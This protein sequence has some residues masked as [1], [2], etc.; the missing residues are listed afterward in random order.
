[1]TEVNAAADA[2][3]RQVVTSEQ[4]ADLAD[5]GNSRAV[6]AAAGQGCMCRKQRAP[7][8]ARHSVIADR[9]FRPDSQCAGASG[10]PSSNRI[11]RVPPGRGCHDAIVDPHTKATAR[12][13]W[14]CSTPISRAFADRHDP[15]TSH[16][17]R[18][19]RELV[20]QCSKRV[21]SRTVHPNRGARWVISPLLPTLLCT[22]WR[23][24]PESLPPPALVP[25]RR[26]RTAVIVTPMIF[27]PYAIRATGREQVR[28]GG[29][30]SPGVWSST[31]TR[32]NPHLRRILG[33]SIRRASD[34]KLR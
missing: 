6:V 15:S 18:S 16:W 28:R 17:G 19:R 4:K 5:W 7:P 27:W 24:P 8:P 20:R 13:V 11:L 14:G 25:G 3:R 1:V 12:N 9:A 29:V 10:S 23:L 34:G 32:P 30:V 21:W 33:F 31:R 22:V 2:G 26:C